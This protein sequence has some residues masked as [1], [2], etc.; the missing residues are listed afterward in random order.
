MAG[1]NQR[2]YQ[3]V[4]LGA[5]LHD[6]GSR[7]VGDTGKGELTSVNVYNTGDHYG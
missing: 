3:A 2:E 4:I 1:I 7:L 5:L 6:I